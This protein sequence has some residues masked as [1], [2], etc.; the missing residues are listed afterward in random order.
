MGAKGPENGLYEIAS[1]FSIADCI[2]AVYLLVLPPGS[3]ASLLPRW[4]DMGGGKSSKGKGK[5]TPRTPFH[6]HVR[7]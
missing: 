6:F 4:T 1:V 3:A 7:A 5:G 2:L